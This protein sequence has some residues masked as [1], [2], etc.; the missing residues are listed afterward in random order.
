[1]ARHAATTPL[2]RKAAEAYARAAALDPA[3]A[4]RFEERRKLLARIADHEGL[5]SLLEEG[6][7]RE[8]TDAGRAA[9][10]AASG[11]AW[12]EAGR[13]A[14][15]EKAYRSALARD[16]KS[17]AA[18][19]G[20]DRLL[21]DQNRRTDLAALREEQ[22]AVA[23]SAEETRA[24]SLQAAEILKDLPGRSAQALSHYRRALA[25]GPADGELLRAVADLSLLAGDESGAVMALERYLEVPPPRNDLVWT[26]ST[27]ARLW[28]ESLGRTGRAAAYCR[29][30][31]EADPQSDEARDR[32]ERLAEQ[33]REWRTLAELLGERC[34]GRSPDVTARLRRLA[35]IY[36]EHLADP[37]RALE[38]WCRVLAVEPDAPDALATVADRAAGLGRWREGASA[39]QRLIARTIDPEKRRGLRLRLAALLGEHPS[40][41][42]VAID[43]LYAVL[44]EDPSEDEAARARVLLR[45]LLEREGRDEEIFDLLTESLADAPEEARTSIFAA[46]GEIAEERLWR[47]PEAAKAYEAWLEREPGN[48][49]CIHRLQGLYRR[50]ERWA[51]LRALLAR[52]RDMAIA[53]ERRLSISLALA[54]LEEEHLGSPR[55]AAAELES[56]LPLS[57]KQ[58]GVIASLARIYREL[59]DHEALHRTLCRERDLPERSDRAGAI[60]LEIARLEAGPLARLESAIESYGR[61]IDTADAPAAVLDGLAR[62]QEKLGRHEDLIGTLRRLAEHVEG[63]EAQSELQV[64]MGEACARAGDVAQAIACHERAAEIVP[65]QPET[66]AALHRLYA[67]DENW[68]GVARALELRVACATEPAQAAALAT[69]LGEIFA[70]RLGNAEAAEAWYERAIALDEG[71]RSAYARLG[72]RRFDESDFESA[73]TLLARAR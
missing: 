33:R 41:V 68:E 61:A 73:R 65:G 31:L 71:C 27:L 23:T 6:A 38:A 69:D 9:L 55:R 18:W 28:E 35:R 15:A 43:H 3:G 4:I 58:A 53:D 36:E 72:T 63:K 49:A 59:G 54:A 24:L 60:H 50:L 21:T 66:L 12:T 37:D 67:Q 42:S 26:L 10:L 7:A 14:E 1:L 51:D 20:L 57:Q 39:L 44:E 22:I 70:D 25:L 34:S 13:A 8:E 5:A 17:G 64:R 46:L 45:V 11:D 29:M 32:L 62:L 40:E 47:A 56:A 52:E 16:R 2:E 19:A 48:L 30:W